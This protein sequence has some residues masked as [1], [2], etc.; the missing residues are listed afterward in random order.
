MKLPKLE[1]FNYWKT[2]MGA[3]TATVAVVA[4]AIGYGGDINNKIHVAPLEKLKAFVVA[5]NQ[6]QDKKAELRSIQ[7]DRRN[8]SGQIFE[9]ERR[10]ERLW[11][12]SPMTN[13]EAVK[14]KK[15]SRDLRRLEKDRD[16]LNARER[17]LK[18]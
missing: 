12:R 15:I 17:E 7:S 14:L 10:Q 6:V 5:Q 16:W 1:K 9:L 18:K 11:A 8:V 4:L 13:I 3:I 2:L